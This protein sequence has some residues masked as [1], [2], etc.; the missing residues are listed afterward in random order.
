MREESGGLY[1]C[2]GVRENVMV[3]VGLG[4]VFHNS[5]IVTMDDGMQLLSFPKM[6][7]SS[8]FLPAL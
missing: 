8:T 3:T 1:T 4:L 5:C 2:L 6:V 7:C